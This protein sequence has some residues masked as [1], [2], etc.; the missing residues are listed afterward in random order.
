MP[1]GKIYQNVTETVGDTPLTWRY[2]RCRDDHFVDLS[3]FYHTCHYLRAWAYAEVSC[4]EPQ[5]LTC[6]LTT[7]GPAD[8]WLNRQHIFHTAANSFAPSQA[9]SSAVRNF[10]C[11]GLSVRTKNVTTPMR[12][13]GTPSAMYIH[14]QP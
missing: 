5:E 12:T 10:A 6:I 3:A 14:C 11:S 2:A 7:N 1:H 4:A 13:V 9:F 8:V